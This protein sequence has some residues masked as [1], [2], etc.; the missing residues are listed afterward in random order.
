MS[1]VTDFI[2]SFHDPAPSIVTAAVVVPVVQPAIPNKVDRPKISNPFG[3]VAAKPAVA[4]LAKVV[5]TMMEGVVFIYRN[6]TFYFKEA[7]N[8]LLSLSIF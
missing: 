1:A 3:D 5:H 7:G 2:F 4:R 8:L 6:L